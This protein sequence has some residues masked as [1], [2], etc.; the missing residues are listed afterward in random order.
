MR[1][2]ART[3]LMTAAWVLTSL[4]GCRS[5]PPP[6]VEQQL[7]AA[8]AQL[9]AADYR[10]DFAGLQRLHDAALPL[11]ADPAWGYLARYW[12]GF[13]SWRQAINGASQGMSKEE[14][15]AHLE[16]AA[17][18]FDASLRLREDF[19]DSH[20]AAAAVNGWLSQFHRD[21]I[22]AL[23]K[24]IEIYKQHLARAKELEPGNPRVLW[25][26]AIPYLVLPAD[27][28]GDRARAVALYRR[29]VE[30]SGSPTAISP[31]PDWGKPE[32]LM[33]L[34]FVHLN[35]PAPD[36]ETAEK[37]AREALRLQPEW[38]YVKDVL[39]PQIEKARA[40]G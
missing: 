16:R 20:A 39:L 9:M 34:A 36:L 27:K 25:V 30:V 28:G 32:G 11:A 13:A 17:A 24:G 31:L 14:L 33:S 6:T 29:M 8:K 1:L 15:Q 4:A 35:L 21:D 23:R 19:A 38:S 18:D 37:E 22:A 2:Q 5:T 10:A 40:G 26:E 3:I 7:T 12:A